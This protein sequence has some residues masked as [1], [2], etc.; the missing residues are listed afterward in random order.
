MLT[1]AALK[2]SAVPIR[3]EAPRNGTINEEQER[4]L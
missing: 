2:M 3:E 1:K 4:E